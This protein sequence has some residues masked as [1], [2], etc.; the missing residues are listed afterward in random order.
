MKTK[1]QLIN[2]VIGQLS[3]IN[4][5]MDNKQDCFL[6]ITQIK[7]ARSALNSVMDKYIEDNFSE[8]ISTCG[9]I[10]KKNMMKKLILELTKK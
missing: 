3:G 1:E 4:K 7:A 5:M 8:C 2:N 10:N 6:V 9:S